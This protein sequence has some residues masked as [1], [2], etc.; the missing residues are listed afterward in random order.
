MRTHPWGVLALRER[1]GLLRRYRGMRY[2]SVVMFIP[3]ILFAV[4]DGGWWR[5]LIAAVL[6]LQAIDVLLLGQ[7]IEQ[8]SKS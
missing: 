7:R 5:W 6:T 4:S 2:V 1:A 3:S 8:W